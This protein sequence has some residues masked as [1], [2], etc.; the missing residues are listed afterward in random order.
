MPWR[1]TKEEDEVLK[2]LFGKVPDEEILKVL[3]RRTKEGMTRRAKTLGL[4]RPL[5]IDM[6]Y[7]KKLCELIEE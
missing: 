4:S 5:E 2:K 6:E 7:F 3:K 1:W